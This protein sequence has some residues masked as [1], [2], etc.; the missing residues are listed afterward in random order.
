[1]NHNTKFWTIGEID[2]TGVRGPHEMELRNISNANYPL[3]I[4]ID[5]DRLGSIVKDEIGGIIENLGFNED[6]TISLEM[7]PQVNIHL[8]FTDYGDEF[9]DKDEGEFKFYLS[10][11]RVHWVPGEDSATYIDIIMDFLERKIKNKTPFEENYDSKTELMKKVL[12]QRSEPF[13]FLKDTDKQA[14]SEF[15]GAEV[16]KVSS[17]W[18]IKKETFPKISIE[19]IWD[20]KKGL[21]IG[22]SGENLS[23]NL[24]RYH[25]EFLGIFLINHVLRFITIRNEEKDLPDI[26]KIMFSRYF[27]KQKNWVHRTR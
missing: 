19:I 26:C 17:G 12:I 13:K 2:A 25:V 23:K 14:L 4:N 9:G 6:W 27:T 8:A 7:F 22:F 10:G 18:K 11:E 21:D 15:L 5:I 20:D 1:M 24:D 3:F 16:W